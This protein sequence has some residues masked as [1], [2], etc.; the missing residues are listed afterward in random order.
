VCGIPITA[1]WLGE[2][3]E[4][5]LPMHSVVFRFVADFGTSVKICQMASSLRDAILVGR[6]KNM[7]DFTAIF[8]IP[9]P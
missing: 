6:A 9:A 4:I 2:P 8:N 1:K 5:P 3:G 7:V